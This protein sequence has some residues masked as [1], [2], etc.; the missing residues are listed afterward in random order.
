MKFFKCAFIS[1]LASFLIPN[2]SA[3]TLLP[4]ISREIGPTA[5]TN[6]EKSERLFCYQISNKPQNYSG[7]TLDNMAIKG[8][9][10]VI[11]E[12]LK[13]MLTEQLLASKDNMD[14]THTENCTIEP[15][16]MLR[17]VRGIDNTDVLISAPCHSVSIFYAGSVKTF[18][19]K[20]AADMLD[21]ILNAFKSKQTS[22][23]SPALLNQLLPVG[24]VQTTSQKAVINES[25]QV[26]PKTNWQAPQQ[27][28]TPSGNKGWNSLNFSK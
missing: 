18:N 17:Y 5:T 26:K 24:V 9:C 7:Y 23:I 1:I 14:F 12:G 22:F 4:N 10:G 19:M 16:I 11:D 28:P 6:I 3:Q 15:Q 2:A 27:N 13:T 25:K 8:F 21:S 20:P